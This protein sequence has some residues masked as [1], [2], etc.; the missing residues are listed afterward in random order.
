MKTPICDFV[1]EYVINKAER[2]HMPGHKG[3]EFLGF[4]AYDITEIDG[5]DS[6]YEANGIIKE[7]EK[8]ASELFGCDTFYSTEGSSQCIKAMVHLATLHAKSRG[9]SPLIAAGRNAHKAF[10]SALALTDC[11]VKWIYP[12][13]DNSYLTCNITAKSLK[14]FLDGSETTPSAVYIT[15][16][17]YLGNTVDIK[18]ISE[19]CK[20]HDIL[21]L[22]DNAH[23]AYLKFL[24]ESK[25]PMDMGADLCCDSAHKTLPV[26]TGGAYLH[27][28]KN[29]EPFFKENAKNALMLYGSTS[30][31]Y[32]IM[33]SLDRANKYIADGYRENLADFCMKVSKLKHQLT[34]RGFT[35]CGNEML[36]ITI[37]TKPYGYYGTEIAES[38]KSKN[39]FCEFCDPDFIVF[40]L[41]PETKDTT[42]DKLYNSLT[43]FEKKEKISENPPAISASNTVMTVREAIFSPCETIPANQ[44]IGRILAQA[45]VACPPAVPIAVCGEIITE[46]SVKCFDYYGIKECIVIKE[47]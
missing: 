3:K 2:L 33:Q 39:L 8:N 10:M 26:L 19:V 9:K 20:S 30:P 24:H 32:L 25:H 45:N 6:L 15:N 17:D 7:S 22:V 31:S 14:K 41:T 43:E 13:N 38:L 36:K 5:A 12:E 18:A 47:R 29:A 44:S 35:L 16:P 28:S 11:G 42:L 21:L 4:E 34:E 1:N 37:N 23:G 40:M 46:Q 27:I